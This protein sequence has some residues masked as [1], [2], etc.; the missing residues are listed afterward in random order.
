ME[1]AYIIIAIIILAVALI[2]VLLR[3]KSAPPPVTDTMREHMQDRAYQEALG[4]LD[5]ARARGV[6]IVG[7]ANETAQQI[8]DNAAHMDV[9]YKADVKAKL[10]SVFDTQKELM[11]ASSDD[12]IKTWQGELEAVRSQDAKVFAS[13][14][15][16]I[17]QQ[18]VKEID[19]FKNILLR[20]TLGSQ[21]AIEEKFSESYKEAETEL[22]T[23]KKDQM[24]S[25]D[26]KVTSVLSDVAKQVLGKTIRLDE[27][28]ELVLNALEKAKKDAIL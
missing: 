9:N 23:Y 15:T 21:K 8:I 5:L 4:I 2:A 22:Q 20:E 26:K 17:E 27:H 10:Q 14:A 24:A 16:T 19:D 13:I 3:Q 1:T 18:A 6:T 25:I 7:Q 12:L 28:E 11:Q